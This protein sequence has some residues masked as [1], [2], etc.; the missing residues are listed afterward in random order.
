MLS[1]VLSELSTG[2]AIETRVVC[3]SDQKFKY[4]LSSQPTVR[5]SKANEN[6]KIDCELIK[7]YQGAES[8]EKFVS[9]LKYGRNQSNESREFRILL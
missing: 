6:I 5:S 3:K 9:E 8:I 2:K 7:I 1:W 4:Q